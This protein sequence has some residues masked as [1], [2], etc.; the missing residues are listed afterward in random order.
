MA[1]PLKE[2]EKPRPFELAGASVAGL[3]G[4]NGLLFVAVLFGGDR[5]QCAEEAVHLIIDTSAEPQ[6]GRGASGAIVAEGQGPDAVNEDEGIVWVTH[7]ANEFLGK[8]CEGGA[9]SAAE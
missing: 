4:W 2:I 7:E 1:V 6:R 5:G 9:P 8:A 3:G